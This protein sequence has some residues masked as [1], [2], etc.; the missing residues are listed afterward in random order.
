M[1]Y[2][3]YEMN[4]ENVLKVSKFTL[5]P[6]PRYIKLGP[7]S[8]EEFRETILIPKV[9]DY[10]D[11]LIIDFDGVLG[12]GSSFLEEAFGGAVRQGIDP[13]LL[14]R[15]ISNAK[16]EDEPTLKE[17]I[18]GYIRDAAALKNKE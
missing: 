15:I 12:Y 2:Q 10:K 5:Y 1:E 16:C 6:G 9:G 7:S 11:L 13:A 14:E 4:Q 3:G 8:G 18:S 17:E